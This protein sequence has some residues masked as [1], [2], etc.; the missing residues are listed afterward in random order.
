MSK[1]RRRDPSTIDTQLVEI[2]EDLANESEVIRLKAAASLL[3]KFSP[4]NSPTKDQILGVLTRLVRG[5]CSSRKA[6]RLGFSIALTEFLVQTHGRPEK[7]VQPQLDSQEVIETLKKQTIAQG[8]SSGNVLFDFLSTS[9]L[10]E[11]QE[12]KNH[13][14]GRLFGA[15][16][17][18]KSRVIFCPNTSIEPWTQILDV[19]LELGEKRTWLRK[20]CGWVLYNVVEIL[21]KHNDY[22]QLLV[23][24]ISE[25][26]FTKTPE[27]VAIWLRAQSVWPSVRFPEGSWHGN[28]PLH[29]KELKNL[30]NVLREGPSSKPGQQ[31]E[32]ETVTQKGN[33]SP[34]LHFAWEVVIGRVLDEQRSEASKLRK[35]TRNP[36][37]HE[38]WN[39]A[40]D[41]T[42]PFKSILPLLILKQTACFLLHLL[43]SENIGA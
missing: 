33:L 23:D 37:F 9:V 42:I 36:T 27:G 12:A 14:F 41:G 18:I 2:Y 30:A 38:F 35:K 11:L 29:R 3:S 19:I 34:D 32:V 24:K 17:V 4:A 43:I 1:K 28:D 26:G 40:V 21:G 6:A 25:H 8:D 13:D 16:A 7:D 10:I 20:E 39:E 5:L 15:E 31:I 22:I